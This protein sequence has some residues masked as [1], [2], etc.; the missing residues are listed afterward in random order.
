MKP[1]PGPA[2]IISATQF[3]AARAAL[4]MTVKEVCRAA[5]MGEG[6][7]GKLEAG[8]EVRG[9]SADKLRVVFEAAGVVFTDDG[10]GLSWA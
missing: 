2:V 3:R 10:H 4:G 6:T 8:G 5:G 9:A 1:A 7:L